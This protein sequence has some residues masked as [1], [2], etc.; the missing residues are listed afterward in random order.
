M[1]CAILSVSSSQKHRVPILGTR[2]HQSVLRPGASHSQPSSSAAWARWRRDA[3]DSLST[4]FANH[5]LNHILV[6]LP[7]KLCTHNSTV[8][9]SDSSA[10]RG[11]AALSVVEWQPRRF[12][13]RVPKIE[14]HE[15]SVAHRLAGP[16]SL[17][18]IWSV[19]SLARLFASSTLY[20]TPPN[21]SVSTSC[22]NSFTSSGLNLHQR[23]QVSAIWYLHARSTKT[24]R[25]P[26]SLSR[27]QR[28]S[29]V[30][31]RVDGLFPEVRRDRVAFASL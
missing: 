22:I 9:P 26:R 3:L 12:H 1:A 16:F 8:S 29:R 25:A 27:T 24:A 28:E 4:L 15:R 10:R 13:A 14:W 30:S 7:L 20:L 19:I 11:L 23:R 31:G 2:E 21:F 17:F 18:L 6:P 5:H